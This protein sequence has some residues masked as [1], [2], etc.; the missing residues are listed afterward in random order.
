MMKIDKKIIKKVPN[1]FFY[2]LMS[3]LFILL[4]YVIACQATGRVPMVFGHSVLRI[5]TPSME[6]EIPV[7]S[8]I[9]IKKVSLPELDEDDVITF[10]SLDPNIYR[11]PNTH[12]IK[13]IEKVDGEYF[14]TTK[15][16]NNQRED[17]YKVPGE[18]VIG[19]YVSRLDWVKDFSE[20]IFNKFVFLLL[21]FIPC[22]ILIAASVVEIRKRLREGKIEHLVQKEVEK[23]KL[24]EKQ[25]EME[26]LI[27][28]D[29]QTEAE[30]PSFQNE[31]KKIKKVNSEDDTD[32]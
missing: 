14:F 21:I 23:L 25:R 1:I 17:D 28:Q 29:R 4:A 15:G 3:F 16:D 13:N 18:D 19:V 8:Y 6:E 9:L 2:T 7:G 10:Y 30:K 5:A 12:R 26:N 27:L 20:F 11:A 32:A 31:Q 22:V 24:Q